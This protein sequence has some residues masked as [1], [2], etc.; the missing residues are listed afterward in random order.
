MPNE[1]LFVSGFTNLISTSKNQLFDFSFNHDSNNFTF[2]A[3][4][5]RKYKCMLYSLQGQLLLNNEVEDN[6]QFKASNIPTGLIIYSI[7]SDLKVIQKGKVL[8]Y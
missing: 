1:T 7:I 6:S 2:K 5:S 8:I 3:P 4:D